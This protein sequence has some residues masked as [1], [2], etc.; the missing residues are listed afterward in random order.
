MKTALVM[1][2]TFPRWK[3]DTTPSFVYEL[4]NRLAKKGFKT[5]VLA[6]HAP[7]STRDEKLGNVNIHRFQYFIPADLQ[8]LAYGAGI[9]PNVKGSFLA[10]LQIPFFLMSEFLAA[11][12]LIRRH[13]PDIIHAHWIVPQGL[14]AS[15]LKSIYKKPLIV[16]IHGSDLFPLKNS[17]F[18]YIQKSVLN[19]CD[20]CTVNS[21]ATKNEVIRRFPEFSHKIKVIPMGVDTKFFV[22][23]NVKFKYKQYSNK[24]IA[25]FVGRLNEQKGIEYLI[26]SLKNVKQ[27]FPN[28]LLL[29]IGEGRY[30]EKL[31]ELVDSLELSDFVEF[32]GAVPHSKII[33]YYNLA[34]VFVMPSITSKIGT[35]GQGLVLLEAMACG[36]CVIGTNTGGIPFIIKNNQSGLLVKEKSQSDLANKIIKIIGDNKLRN[37]FSKNASKFVK[38]NYSWQKIV[39]EFEKI[40]KKLK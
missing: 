33:D 35:E 1:T 37:N 28:T 36:T 31:E 16:T 6:P 23:K 19:A 30:R 39:K 29:I 27:K 12:N 15:T 32:L 2:S 4:S 9:I 10:K 17:L 8:R 13:D 22:P 38:S 14:L 26:K 7:Q 25:L 34:D 3:N 11:G 5:I 24:K 21:I 20:V 18:R 40:Y